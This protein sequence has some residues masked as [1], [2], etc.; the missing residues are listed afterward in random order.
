MIPSHFG[1][2]ILTDHRSYDKL[3]LVHH[4]ET[5][6]IWLNDHPTIWSHIFTGYQPLHQAASY[7]GPSGPVIDSFKVGQQI[8]GQGRDRLDRHPRRYALRWL[9]MLEQHMASGILHNDILNLGHVRDKGDLILSILVLDD[10]KLGFDFILKAVVAVQ[11]LLGP[12][13]N[14]LIRVCAPREN[15]SKESCEV[16]FVIRERSVA[17]LTYADCRKVIR[18]RAIKYGF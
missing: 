7:L 4:R 10:L 1:G 3:A 9:S 11:Y 15:R 2:E 8:R 13:H 14:L 12:H 6:D 16:F 18:K 5:V 17:G